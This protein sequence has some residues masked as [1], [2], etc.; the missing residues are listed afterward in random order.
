MQSSFWRSSFHER[1][2]L[3]PATSFS[4][5]HPTEKHHGHKA[6]VWFGLNGDQPRPLFAFAGLWRSWRGDL[7]GEL[8]E[9]D[10]MAFLTTKPN[11]VVKPIHP[12]RMPVILNPD[13]YDTW[14]DGSPDHALKLARPY[15]ADDMR[16]VY[17]GETKDE[18][19]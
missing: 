12:N 2:C 6:A 10:V 17:T 3:V 15:A 18:A 8:V 13:D 11:A 16:I 14:L 5:Y 19:A 4:E 1:R 9:L 7:K